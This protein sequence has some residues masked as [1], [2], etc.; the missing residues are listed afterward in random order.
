MTRARGE[1]PSV[2]ALRPLVVERIV[3]VDGGADQEAHE[4][5]VCV[6][7]EGL[8]EKI[9]EVVRATAPQY[10]ELLLGDAVADP[11]ETHVAGLCTLQ[12]DAVVG[13]A[14]SAGIVA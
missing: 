1:A 4:G 6:D 10:A 11:V 3:D 7:G 12:L 5:L 13:D 9:R 14:H 8:G 2:G